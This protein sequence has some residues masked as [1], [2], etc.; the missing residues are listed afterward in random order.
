MDGPTRRGITGEAGYNLSCQSTRLC[1]SPPG[2]SPILLP[3]VSPILHQPPA[4]SPQRESIACC[5]PGQASATI[6]CS[7]ARRYLRYGDSQS[8]P[9]PSRWTQVEVQAVSQ[10]PLFGPSPIQGCQGPQIGTREPKGYFL[11]LTA[12]PEQPSGHPASAHPE[13]V[14]QQFMKCSPIF[15]WV[16]YWY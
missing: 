5:S 15:H 8:P 6:F 1:K 11:T 9:L 10:G 2:C 14:A 3:R 7:S 12:S 13:R 4:L 16:N